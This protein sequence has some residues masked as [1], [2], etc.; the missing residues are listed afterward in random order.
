MPCHLRIHLHQSC[1]RRPS[2]SLGRVRARWWPA[3]L[4]A[5]LLSTLLGGAGPA[6]ADDDLGDPPRWVWHASSLPPE[7]IERDGGV[8]GTPSGASRHDSGYV[9]TTTRRDYALRR[10]T[11]RF[12]GNG[13]VYRVHATPNFVDVAGSLRGFYNRAAEHEY[14]A[15]GGFRF[16]QVIDWEEVSFGVARPGESNAAY[17]PDRF[18]AL[19]AS[20]GQPQLAGF[21]AGHPAWGQEPWLPYAAC[22]GA[23]V[24]RA[25]SARAARSAEECGPSRRPYDAGLEFWRRV[26][27]AGQCRTGGSLAGARP[28]TWSAPRPAGSRRTPTRPATER[29]RSGR[30]RGAGG[31]RC[32]SG[33]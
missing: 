3:L 4:T 30:G 6:G 24:S 13:Y 7:E 33:P 9:G 26:R 10:I 20:P 5:A 32:P 28:C 8:Q 23:V 17:D 18:R 1:P 15:M 25:R 29:E 12:N 19:R 21:P 16:D 2:P 14:A 11:E 22:G 27:Q 31:F